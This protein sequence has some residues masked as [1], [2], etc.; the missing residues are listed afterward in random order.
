MS[1]FTNIVPIGYR[2]RP[3]RRLRSH[4]GYESRFPF[5]WWLTPVDGLIRFLRDWDVERLYDRKRLRVVQRL[6]GQPYV[7]N[8]EYR[9]RLVHEFPRGRRDMILNTWVDHIEEARSKTF[10]AMEKFD[11]LNAPH[12]RVLFVRNMAQDEER[13]PKEACAA[14]REAVLARMPQ[15]DC[16]FLLISTNGVEAEGWIP[17]KVV[18]RSKDSWE[19]DPA[20]WDPPLA[21]LGFTLKQKPGEDERERRRAAG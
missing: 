14:L 2:C 11:A 16:S 1:N 10:Y 4:F 19:G 12:R 21:S 15:A 5:D 6:F 17:L 9:I 3:T 7:E 8:V 13:R 18:D 20:A